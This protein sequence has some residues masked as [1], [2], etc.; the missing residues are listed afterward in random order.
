MGLEFSYLIIMV[1]KLHRVV[2]FYFIV[3]SE[4]EFGQLLVRARAGDAHAISD[5]WS[6][7]NP[8][9]MRYVSVIVRDSADDICQETWISLAKNLDKF[10]GSQDDM[11][12]YLIKIARNRAIDYKRAGFRRENLVRHLTVYESKYEAETV[13][14][15]ST[16]D[17]SVVTEVLSCLSPIAAEVIFLRHI[18]GL[19]TDEIAELVNRSPEGVRVTIHRG[20]TKLR[21]ELSKV[22][23]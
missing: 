18:A 19:T 11:R 10:E 4:M 15:V 8:V 23:L 22:A 12:R 17:V 1:W 13:S 5:L 21:Q 3:L 7:F 2:I 14:H 6:N 20:L 9:L 16:E